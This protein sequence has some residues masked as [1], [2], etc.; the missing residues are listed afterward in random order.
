MA[1]LQY[2]PERRVTVCCPRGEEPTSGNNKKIS[3]NHSETTPKIILSKRTASPKT[4]APSLTT[5]TGRPG[6]YYSDITHCWLPSMPPSP[7]AALSDALP[8]MPPS[9]IAALSDALSDGQLS[10]N[11]ILVA[12]F[13]VTAVLGWYLLHF[14]VNR[15]GGGATGRGGKK[16]GYWSKRKERKAKVEKVSGDSVRPSRG[17]SASSKKCEEDPKVG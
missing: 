3:K 6:V 16:Q 5:S 7:I 9:P 4:I 8:S 14:V 1:L 11:L 17:R 2:V 12:V 10:G 13:L 15:G